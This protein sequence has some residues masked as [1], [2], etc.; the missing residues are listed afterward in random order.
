MLAFFQAPKNEVVRFG[1]RPSLSFPPSELYSFGAEEDFGGKQAAAGAP[2]MMRVNFFG[3]IGPSG[4]LPL[5]YTEL[6]ADRVQ[7][8]DRTL[9]DFLDIFHHRSLSLFYRAWEKSRFAVPYERG[10]ED[11]FSS[12]LLSVVGLGLASLKHRQL[13]N[14]YDFLYYGGLLAQ[15]PRS[16][17]GLELMLEDYFGIPVKVKQFLGAWYRLDKDAQCSLDDG[18]NNSQQLG[19]GTVVGD[20]IWDP[21]SHARIVLGPLSLQQYRDFLPTGT[22]FQPLRSMVR[23]YAGDELD[24]EVQLIMRKEEAPACQLGGS[25]GPA[26][27]LGWLTWAKTTPMQANPGQTVMQL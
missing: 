21:Q 14:D 20:E 10:E 2:P 12:Y 6:A 5:Y 7:A 4:Q 26:P 11:K 24:F 16:A 8:R 13:Q 23:F 22:A 19:F 27:Q 25:D 17:E 18:E 15:Q 3:L 9:R 1:V